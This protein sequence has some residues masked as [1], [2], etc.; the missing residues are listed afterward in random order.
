MLFCD[1]KT[2]SGVQNDK[3]AKWKRRLFSYETFKGLL[4]TYIYRSIKMLLFIRANQ[5]YVSLSINF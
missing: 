4:Q 2:N 1:S 5:L 3:R